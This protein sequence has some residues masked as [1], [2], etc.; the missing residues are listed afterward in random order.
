MSE[1]APRIGL[2]LGS[3][4]ARGLA[5]I[6]AFEALDRLGIKPAEIAGASI[7]AV[8]GAAYAAGFS[9]KAL[10]A[11]AVRDFRDRAEVMSRLF[12]AR[13]GRISDFWK[14]GLANPVLIDAA[15]TLET[16]L[17]APLPARFEDLDIPLSVIAADL[18]RMERVVLSEGLLIPAVAASMAIPGLV[19]PVVHE[20][21]VLIDGGAVDPLPIRAIRQPVDLIIAI[22]ISRAAAREETEAIP[23]MVEVVTRAFDLMQ[24]SLIDVQH[25]VPPAP[26]YRIKAKVENFGALDFFAAKKILAAA[27]PIAAEIETIVSALTR[28]SSSLLL[29]K[30][31]EQVRRLAFAKAGIN[32]RRVMAG[33]VREN[34]RAMLD[35]P[36]LGVRC[37]VI[38]TPDPREGNRAGAHR[39][40]FERDVEITIADPFRAQLLASHADGEYLGMRCG[41]TELAR[42]VSRRGDE[43]ALVHDGRADRHLTARARRAGLVESGVEPVAAS[44]PLHGRPRANLSIRPSLSRGASD[45]RAR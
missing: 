15:A 39:A 6:V 8:L 26:L 30:A 45:T 2:V 24:S 43:A 38:E 10:R 34:A 12:K 23:G 35:S 17:P 22:D 44:R 4:G 9:G 32:L 40:R 21:R 7:G 3:G 1:T 19:R 14:Q 5:H 29:K 41:I 42:A 13:V 11:H 20:G 27:E 31:L 36:A 28:A 16:F 37:R 33:R 25:H 18:H